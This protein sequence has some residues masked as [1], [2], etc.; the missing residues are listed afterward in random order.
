MQYACYPDKTHIAAATVTRTDFEI[1]K[2]GCHI[3]VKSKPA[4][5]QIAD[6]GVPRYDEFDEEFTTMFPEVVK[7]LKG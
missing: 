2:V 4:W 6:D 5:H 1:P 7:E 3:F